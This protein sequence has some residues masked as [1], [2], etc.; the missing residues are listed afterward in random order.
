MAGKRVLL[1]W[2]LGLGF[3]YALQLREI[4][5]ALLDAG[6]APVVA[7]RSFD[8]APRLYR[9]CGFPVV[10]APWIIGRFTPTAETPEFAPTGFA[11]LM[12]CNGFGAAD[13]LR[14]IQQ[15]WRGLIDVLRPD[16]VVSR[17]A[18]HLT[19]A[20]YGRIPTVVFGSAYSTP[21]ANGEVF[22]R[23]RSDIAPFADQGRMLET[24]RD[25][26]RA[27]GA[28][29]PER[30]TDVGRGERRVIATLPELDPYH[31]TRVEPCA[32]AFDFMPPPVADHDGGF[33]AYLSGEAPAPRR[34]AA[35]L[36]GS[37]LSGEI[38]VR[39]AA[40]E[41]WELPRSSTARLLPTAPPIVDAVRRAAVVVN[42]AS[43]GTVQA[44][45]AAG[46]PQAFAPQALDQAIVA[47]LLKDRPFIRLLAPDGPSNEPADV[48][49]ALMADEAAAT[50]AM[51][52]ARSI[53]ARGLHDAGRQVVLACLDLLNG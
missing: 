15:A 36:L 20:A 6:H 8:H 38:H 3:G 21:P 47:V 31:A 50:A 52:F 4:A 39:D 7:L 33:Y 17:Y 16:L 51:D 43:L 23:F 53:Q 18:P 10:Q 34:I 42:H 12:A 48:T 28:A 37:G 35:S 45:L 49:S 5:G 40:P 26:Q 46:R 41:S 29:L 24:V 32:G 11:D 44:A 2:E 9:D 1:G 30:I 27:F 14:S 25:V 13:H 19:L 22:P